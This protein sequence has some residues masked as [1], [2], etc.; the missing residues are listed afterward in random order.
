MGNVESLFLTLVHPICTFSIWNALFL[1][2]DNQ[3]LCKLEDVVFSKARFFISLALVLI[4]LYKESIF[5]FPETSLP[6]K[7]LC[8]IGSS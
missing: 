8:F 2:M 7:Q 3:N 6:L 1:H 5:L 4:K